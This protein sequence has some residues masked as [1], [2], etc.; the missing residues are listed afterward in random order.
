MLGLEDLSYIHGQLSNNQT[1]I[2]A[3]R[4]IRILSNT[5]NPHLLIISHDVLKVNGSWTSNT[6]G[7]CPNY[8]THS[9][10]PVFSLDLRPAVTAN[11]AE[12]VIKILAPKYV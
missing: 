10:N 6:A 7:G 4:C 3:I 11:P 9:K 12:V 5:I 2:R 1:Q 8:P